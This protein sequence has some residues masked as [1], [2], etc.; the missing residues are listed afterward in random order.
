MVQE[1]LPGRHNFI[2]LF[3]KTD[4]PKL[5]IVA[6]MDTVSARGMKNPFAATLE[7]NRIYGRGAC[8]DKGPLASAFAVLAGLTSQKV[9]LK[10]DVTF[11]GTVDEECSMSGAAMFA[12]I[13]ESYDLCIALEPTGLQLI[14]A[15]KGVYRF[16][17]FTKGVAAHSS[18][19]EQGD[20]SIVKMHA[21][22]NDLLEY[23]AKIGS[24]NDPELGKATLAITQINGG[25]VINIIPDRCS[26]SVDIR[27]LPIQGPQKTAAE[28][29]KLIGDRGIM[30]KIF[31][32]KGIHSSLEEIH[33][34]KFLQSLSDS[35]FPAQATTA[36][37]A[38]DCS[39]LTE[40]GP[41]VVWGPGSIDQAHKTG[42]YI[43]T[44]QIEGACRILCHFLTES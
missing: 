5:L 10:Y 44:S 16:Q 13:G 38:T 20:N 40:K 42:E 43:E 17:V 7:N 35:G 26:L 21:I 37:Y 25:S 27:L 41:C 29:K 32:A 28:L 39:K 31:S 24:Q 1:A 23:G 34:Q 14:N 30:R 19:P 9:P 22:I 2:C 3:P 15:H 6:H 4:A 18:S 33:I 8:D 36:S 11:V 12:K